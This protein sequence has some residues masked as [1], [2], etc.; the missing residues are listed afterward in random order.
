MFA[1]KLKEK[2]DDGEEVEDEYP[3]DFEDDSEEE[4]NN[5]HKT[6]QILVP[7]CKLVVVSLQ[8]YQAL[9]VLYTRLSCSSF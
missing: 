2:K 6:D 3:D 1:T 7:C 4:V 5:F 8:L 9:L